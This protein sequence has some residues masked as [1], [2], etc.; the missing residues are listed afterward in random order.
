LTATGAADD[1]KLLDASVRGDERAARE[2]VRRHGA[3]LHA[4]ALRILGDTGTAEEVVQ[5]T[6]DQLFRSA[7]K[8]RRDSRLSTWL[9]TVMLN[10][11]RDT[12]RRSSFHMAMHVQPLATD[13]PDQSTD[14]HQSLVRRER[15]ARVRC[16]LEA[17]S[18][19]LREVIALRFASGL[20][21]PEIAAI[22]GC[23]E[24]TVASRLHRGLVRLGAQLR[25]SGFTQEE[26]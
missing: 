10:R 9:H 11:C 6:F 4:C 24:G 5:D 26:A 23:A 14:A 25:A 21:Y 1:W 2:L 7:R 19:D 15:D 13:M 18:S 3:R 16:A 22:L 20:S 8:L 12:L 17:L